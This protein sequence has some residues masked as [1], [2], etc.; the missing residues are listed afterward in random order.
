M[1]SD[2]CTQRIGRSGHGIEQMPKG[3]LFPLTRDDLVECTVLFDAVRRLTGRSWGVPMAYR[4]AKLAQ[5]IRGWMGYWH[6][7]RTLATQTGMTNEW[8]RHQGLI[9]VR[10]LW[11]KA[12]GYA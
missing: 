3:R 8:L 2:T 5:Y 10:N 7:A 4:L 1:R 9:N 12:H 6:L 11:I